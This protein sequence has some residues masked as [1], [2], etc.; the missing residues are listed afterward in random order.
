[1][2]SKPEGAGACWFVGATYG[3]TTKASVRYRGDHALYRNDGDYIQM[4]VIEAFRDAESSMR[5]LRAN[6]PAGPNT[7]EVL[8][9]DFGRKT[10]ATRDM[11]A[12]SWLP[13]GRAHPLRRPWHTPEVR[14][15][16][17]ILLSP[18]WLTVHK[19]DKRATFSA[20]HSALR[21]NGDARMPE[22]IGDDLH[23]YAGRDRQGCRADE[24]TPPASRAFTTDA[25]IMS[26]WTAS[27]L[28]ALGLQLRFANRARHRTCGP[29][30]L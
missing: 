27:S 5:P 17:R 11:P 15:G 1:M 23:R 8:T 16:Q 21:V 28:R 9:G 18:T 22:L 6:R 20:T 3:G 10:W 30:P 29:I 2:N 26:R 7:S 12:R 19:N 14:E 24:K 25:T 4:P 13:N